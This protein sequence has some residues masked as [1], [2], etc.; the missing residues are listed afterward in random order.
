M[1]GKRRVTLELTMDQLWIVNA[2]LGRY[3]NSEYDEYAKT[4]D[5]LF[6]I[7]HA[8]EFPEEAYAYREK[9]IEKAKAAEAVAKLVTQKI[10][11]EEKKDEDDNTD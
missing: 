8:K 6:A 7:F 1:D 9:L 2:A 5:V 10:I 3:E 4:D 11:E